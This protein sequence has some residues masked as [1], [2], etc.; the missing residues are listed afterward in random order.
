M[1]IK[2][3][4]QDALWSFISTTMSMGANLIILPFVLT[5]LS[6]DA[7]GLYYIFTTISAIATLFDFGFSPAI[8]RSMA[9]AWSGAD[10]LSKTG[11][12]EAQNSK[13]N[14]RLL[15]IIIRTCRIIYLALGLSALLLLIG[16]GTPYISFVIRSDP[17]REYYIAWIIYII[18]VF[19]NIFYGYYVVFLRGIGAVANVNRIT[20]ASRVIQISLCVVL[21]YFGT[22]LVGVSIAYLMYGLS[23]R[24]LASISFYRYENTGKR[25][26]ENKYKPTINDIKGVLRAIWPN[27]WRDGMVAVANYL[28]NQATTLVASLYLSLH[29]TGVFSL[30]TQLTSAVAQIAGTLY[31][32]YQPALQSAYANRDEENQRRFLS[33]TVTSFIC[34]FM[35][36]MI[37]LCLLGA[38]IIRFIKP[39]Y[40]L[41]IPVLIGVGLYQFML[42]LRNCYCT[43]ISTTNRVIY[44]KSF[45]ISA[46]ICVVLSIIFTKFCALGVWG[47]IYAQII[48]QAIYNIWKWPMF[49][50]RE[51]GLKLSQMIS[52]SKNELISLLYHKQN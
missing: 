38:P 40:E 28:L 7:T 5:N 3:T 1:R 34:L 51:L 19:F 4:K 36:G 26:K 49:V 6:D 43:Y 52:Y 21:L 37:L 30:C 39:S 32:A 18:A 50:H 24:A 31:T 25:L 17:Q 33:I 15:H 46:I 14:Y 13:I 11:V 8:A 10:S 35:I 12:N 23:F 16:V 20:I 48:S 47:L 29:M 45:I 22:G 42:K 9:Y 2:T 27:T 41:S 44:A